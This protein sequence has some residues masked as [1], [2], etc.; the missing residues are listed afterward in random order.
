MPEKPKVIYLLIFAF[1]AAVAGSL[2][3]ASI[4][5]WYLKKDKPQISK[6]IN[7]SFQAEKELPEE[8][9]E[10]S[11]KVSPESEIEKTPTEEAEKPQDSEESLQIFTDKDNN[12]S[13]KLPAD[14]EVVR[15]EGPKGAQRSF[16]QIQS[17]DWEF[18]E[19]NS[20]GPFSSF[21]FKKGARVSIRV[22]SDEESDP[23][24]EQILQEKS[25]NING[26]EAKL[27]KYKDLSLQEGALLDL[28]FSRAGYS[29]LITLEYD[30]ESFDE[31]EFIE[32]LSSYFR[33][34]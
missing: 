8:K 17:P 16:L 12:Y 1:A 11:E 13:L 5:L 7:Q 31:Q 33:F 29:Y 6:Q 14:W 27:H 30:P 28:H 10:A 2:I 26:V 19:E 34:L 9:S 22:F 32:K 20:E 3:T 21:R 15:S 23:V 4:I 18:V 25:I 24:H